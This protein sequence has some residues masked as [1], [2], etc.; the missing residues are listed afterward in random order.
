M[1]F[2]EFEVDLHLGHER[3]I[4]ELKQ[5]VLEFFQVFRELE[6]L[7]EGLASDLLIAGLSAWTSFLLV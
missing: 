6:V 2:K 3:A 4:Q 5:A 7:A 1:S